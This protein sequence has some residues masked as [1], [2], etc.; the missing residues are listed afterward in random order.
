MS[1]PKYC[2]IYL[3]LSNAQIDGLDKL[4][5]AKRLRDGNPSVTRSDVLQELIEQDK[6]TPK[7]CKAK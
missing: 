5:L 3:V 1:K 4:V 7:R 2:E 6:T